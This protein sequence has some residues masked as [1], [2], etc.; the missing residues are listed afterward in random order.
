MHAAALALAEAVDL[1]EDLC[2][3][4]IY[5]RAF[6]DAVA[7]AAVSTLNKIRLAQRGADAGRDGFLADIQ[8]N[9]ARDLAVQEVFLYR[10]L[11]AADGAHGL[12]E[13]SCL[14]FAYFRQCSHTFLKM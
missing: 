12:V 14:L 10:L 6:G 1:S 8:M 5:I 13:F 2:H 7:V 9:E 3:H 11:K 4:F